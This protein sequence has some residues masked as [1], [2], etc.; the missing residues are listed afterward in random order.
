MVLTKYDLLL[1]WITEN[2]QNI[3]VYAIHCDTAEK[4]DDLIAMLYTMGF[5]W[6]NDD[7]A[8]KH[9]EEDGTV[10]TKWKSK[11]RQTCYS[12]TS[13]KIILYGSSSFYNSQGKIIIEYDD[14]FA[15]AE[16][17]SQTIDSDE[18][19]QNF[20][21]NVPDTDLVDNEVAD[22]SQVQV[23][24]EKECPICHNFIQNDG[25]KFCM[26]CGYEVPANFFITSASEKTEHIAEEQVLDDTIN[27]EVEN[28]TLSKAPKEVI[29]NNDSVANE[30]TETQD[31]SFNNSEQTN[32][33]KQKKN[34]KT[35][36]QIV[37]IGV[38]VLLFMG[39]IFGVNMIK[40]NSDND[41]GKF[42]GKWEVVTQTTAQQSE[43]QTEVLTEAHNNE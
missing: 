37:V 29:D 25:S 23:L 4:A 12:V 43:D 15:E 21:D 41:Y 33:K 9:F 42:S 24:Q 6:E 27:N 39:V 38:I 35:I 22:A 32:D 36:I 17:A 11:G 8:N 14:L 34:K 40:S 26:E 19:K 31:S 2:A 20:V 30:L 18:L 28:Q 7:L 5:R 10:T 1:N 16:N 3:L 13:T